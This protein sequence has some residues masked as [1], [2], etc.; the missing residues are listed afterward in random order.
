MK[1][2]RCATQEAPNIPPGFRQ[3]ARDGTRKDLLSERVLDAAK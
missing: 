1:P 2:R 3:R